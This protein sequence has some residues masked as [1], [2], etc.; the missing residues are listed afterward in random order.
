MS[1]LTRLRFA[2]RGPLADRASGHHRQGPGTK[3]ESGLIMLILTIVLMAILS[4]ITVTVMSGAI[5]QL[6]LGS[7]AS[8]RTG[9]LEGALA[10]VQAMVAQIRAASSDGQ[11]ELADL[12]CTISTPPL[13]PALS[14]LTGETNI[15]DSSS[16][17]VSVQYEYLT[18]SGTDM[19]GPTTCTQ[20]T[21]PAYDVTYDGEEAII[22]AAVITSC[23]PT[24]ACPTNPT[25]APTS[26]DTW[27]RVVSTYDFETSYANVPGGLIEN[28]ENS[29]QEQC[30]EAVE[31][32][33]AWDLDVTNSCSSGYSDELF[34]YTSDWNLAI[35]LGGVEYCV[36]DPEDESPASESPIP[37]TTTCGST[38]A[39]QWGVD[40]YGGI[41]GAN[42]SGNP[43]GYCLLNP[44]SVPASGQVTEAATVGS[45]DCDSTMDNA[46]TWQMTPE[47]GAGASQPA[48]GQAFGVTDQLVNFQ[49]FGYCLDVTGQNVGSTYLIDYMCKQF[50]DTSAYPVWNQRWC[51]QQL[52]TN[53]SGLPVG[54][55][56]TPDGQTS[57]SS[58]SSPYC[59]Q[60]PLVTAS[61]NIDA[62]VLVTSCNIDNSNQ[63]TDLLWTQWTS[64]G[65]SEHDYTYTDEDGYCL[66]ANTANKQAPSDDSFSTIQVATC[67][68][69]YEQKWNAPPLLGVSQIVNTHEDTG[70]GAY[71][72]P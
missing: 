6:E 44:L 58:P 45:S 7:T 9:A 53:S 54:L 50:P 11:V 1:P 51:F 42:S 63:A 36:Q 52:S 14:P 22:A 48:T 19:L 70:S 21:G 28:Y 64:N 68:G 61:Q 37:I 3:D 55:V 12:P 47:V 57:C 18:S 13:N 62:Y 23:S 59:L 39:A 8:N 25:A 69:S 24:T 27:R 49:E 60:S 65:G 35:V 32:G 41:E 17:T 56:Y 20:G 16:F 40:D 33:S 10:G 71:S 4:L 67:N 29:T 43:N 66:E 30:L 26:T 38:A 15:S 72:G 46:S 2:R 5:G 31:T 34:Q